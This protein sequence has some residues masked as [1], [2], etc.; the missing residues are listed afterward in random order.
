MAIP[1]IDLQ[2]QRL[3]LGQPLEDA[4]LKVVR[5]GAYIMGPEIAAFE[6]ALGAFGEAPFVLSCGSGTEALQLPLMAWGIGPGDAVFCPSFTFAATAEVMP[7]VGASPV[8]VD[9]LP[10]TFNLDPVRLDAAIEAVKAEGKLTPKAVIAVDL[11]GQPA[12]YPAIAAVAAKH[13]LKLI[14]DSAQGFGCTLNGHH[15]LHW[16]D[17]AT[18]S[19][20]PAKPLGCY[21]D[22]GAVLSKDSAFH[23]LLVSLRVH[24]QAV[25]GDIEGKTFD[26]D[27]KYLNMRVGMNSR[28]DTIQAAVLLQKLSIF[29]DEIE[30][31]NRV[32]DRYAAG[33]S[34]VV[35]TPKV[36][37]GGVSVWAQYTIETSD[38]EGM[39]AHLKEAGVPT[40]VYYPI[41][42]H[43]Q[44]VYSGYP[45]PGGLPV[46]EAKSST[47]MS[48]PMHPYLTADDQDQVISAIRSYAGR[49]L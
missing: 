33:L 11:F 30:A 44:G 37:D 24:G 4:I 8:F 48:L 18:T 28:M 3:R 38:R 36:I 17:V 14:A 10:D 15:P 6:K 32:A 27:P 40:A 5:S 21:G 2:A 9:I 31:R 7:L 47:V 46:T 42:I 22:G 26:H 35:K 29:A 41:P 49:N 34:D 23:D 13:G 43:K 19:F 20:F 12:D 45:A 16:A 39:I 25:K 1:F